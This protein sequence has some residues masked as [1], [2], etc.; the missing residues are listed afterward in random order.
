[1]E[2]ITRENLW[3]YILRMLLD[4]PMYAYEIGK[5]LSQ[6]F[7]FST[8]T[9]TTYV[10]LYKLQREGLIRLEQEIE[11]TGKPK[12]KYYTLT[13]RGREEFQKACRLLQ[14]TLRLLE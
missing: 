8:A 11:S 10:V 7:G 2:K 14:E 5:G 3:I 12:R 13:D 6:R 4:R 9:V 1:M